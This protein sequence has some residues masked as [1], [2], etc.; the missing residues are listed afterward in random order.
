[1]IPRVLALRNFRAYRDVRLELDDSLNVIIGRND[2]GKSTILDALEIFFNNELVKIEVEDLNIRHT[3]PSIS[4]GIAFEVDPDAPFLLDTDV[5]T[6]LR[7]EFLLNADGY[8][9]IEKVWNCASK[10]ITSRSLTTSI[11]SEYPSTLAESPLVTMKIQE[12]RQTAKDVAATDAVADNRVSSAIRAAIYESVNTTNLSTTRVPTDKEDAK[13][14]FGRIQA[15]LP[16]F[17]LFQSD[18]QNK[19]TDRDVQDPLKIITKQAISELETEL[20]HI[21]SKIED[22][23]TEKGRRT[24]EKLA[25]MDPEIAK[26]LSPNVKHKNWDTLF[27]FSFTGDEGIALNKRGSG[28]RRLVLLN[29]FRSE[30]EQNERSKNGTIFAIEEPETSQH[31][32]FQS[33]LVASLIEL[34]EQHQRQVIVTTHSPE[35]AKAVGIDNVHFLRRGHDGEPVLEEPGQATLRSIATALGLLPYLNKTVVCVEG[36][37]D[38]DYITAFNCIPEIRAIIDLEEEHIP[39]IPMTGGN[40]LHWI[41]RNYL[42]EANVSEFHVYDNDVPDYAS[43]VAA[44]NAEGRNRSGTTTTLREMENY[45]HWDLVEAQYSLDRLSFTSQEKADWSNQDIPCKWK[46]FFPTVRKISFPM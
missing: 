27:S 41:D 46:A 39:V 19:D 1:M 36:E 26:T 6:T 20:D 35:I 24:V 45:L 31:P 23:A 14:I 3:E 5:E 2:I 17:A 37:N 16:F 30:A 34:S 7:R 28:I 29:Y 25:E 43:R 22:R 44:M 13:I 32:D 40:L 21:V 11:I 15:Q 12:L 10:T 4:I 38:I 33:M 9:E 18:R 8:L 42:K